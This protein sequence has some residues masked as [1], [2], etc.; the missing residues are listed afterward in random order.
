MVDVT[1]NTASINTDNQKRDDHLRSADFF[2]AEKNPKITFKSKSFIKTGNDTYK[3]TGDL[4]IKDKTKEVV[5][6]TKFKGIAKDPWGNTR[7]GFKATTTIDR[8]D[9]DVV[10]N[11]TLESGG[12]L[13]G[14]TV[15]II[16]NVQF[17]KE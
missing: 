9:F 16:L 3:I 12:L 10:W 15:D 11:K 5:L 1:I 13:V 14:K 4:T 7:A 6:D 17:M 2:N 8:Y